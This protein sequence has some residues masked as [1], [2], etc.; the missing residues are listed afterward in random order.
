MFR[1]C[2]LTR[3]FLVVSLLLG[4]T[5]CVSDNYHYDENH[6]INRGGI[7]EKERVLIKAKNYKGLIALNRD[8]LKKREDPE[9]RLRL[10][11]YYYFAGDYNASLHY[12]KISLQKNPS[13]KVYLLQSK[14]LSAQK[15]H[16]G[17]LKFINMALNKEPGNAEGLNLRGIILAETGDMTGALKSFDL[18]RNAFYP[19]EKVVNNIALVYIT[20]RKYP[21]AVQLLLPVY[22]RGYRNERLTHNLIFALVKTGDLRYAREIIKRENI[23]RHSDMLVSS[24]FEVESN[25][26]SI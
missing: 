23:T 5:A 1:A 12:L 14:N 4:T 25:L 11:E 9:V 8:S 24:L 7:T 21:Q 22:L 19:E 17:A 16:Q 3:F 26:P 10:S 13:V 20:Q 6:Y 2:K 15:N 18:A